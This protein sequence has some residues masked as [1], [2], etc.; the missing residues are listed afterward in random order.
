[1]DIDTEVCKNFITEDSRIK[2]LVQMMDREAKRVHE[3]RSRDIAADS[4]LK[5]R[6]TATGRRMTE[7]AYTTY[8]ETDAFKKT[9]RKSCLDAIRDNVFGTGK[10]GKY[11]YIFQ[12]RYVQPDT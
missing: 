3:K 11:A 6:V 9:V 2:V 4:E 10:S 12:K 1:M 8:Q 7:S 5:K